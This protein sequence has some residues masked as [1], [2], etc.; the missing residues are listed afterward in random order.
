MG[1][2]EMQR[3]FM[4]GS[5][6]TNAIFILRQLQEKYLVKKKN[7][8][9]TFADQVFDQMKKAFD[10]V[11]DDVVWWF[12]RKLGMEEWLIKIQLMYR[13]FI[14]RVRVNRASVMISWSR[15]DYMRATSFVVSSCS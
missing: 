3:G 2:D 12:L 14:G 1:I 8:Y 15:L 6:T 4:P 13:N 5:G 7:L 9:F 11:S 10:Q